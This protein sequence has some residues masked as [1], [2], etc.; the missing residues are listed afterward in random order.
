MLPEKRMAYFM[1]YTSLSQSI[2]RIV[3]IFFN[4]YSSF[5]LWLK[6]EV[7]FECDLALA[8]EFELLAKKRTLLKES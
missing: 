7:C 6:S 5:I 3:K 8:G 1:M 4:V 2:F